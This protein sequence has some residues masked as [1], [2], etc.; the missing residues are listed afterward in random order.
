[1][2]IHCFQHVPFEGPA[3]IARWAS[4]RGHVLTA[5]RLWQAA[6]PEP[7]ADVDWLVIMGGPMNIHEHESYP[8]LVAEKAYIRR[9]IDAGKTV[10]G[11]CLGGQ[12]LADALG[13]AVTRGEQR[14]IGWYPIELTPQ[15]RASSL[16]GSVPNGCSVFHWHGD[17]F[18]IPRGAVRFAG[19]AGCR[20][21]AFLYGGRVLGLQFHLE[22]TP[23]SIAALL[24][25][26]ADE[27]VPATYVQTAEQML[28]RA[29]DRCRDL[30]AILFGILDRLSDSGSVV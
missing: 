7:L 27:V 5:T 26:C 10:I 29:Q 22:S 25:H 28:E 12:L 9:A 20:N 30:N 18:D 2:R 11:V 23:E 16:F 4:N 17:T 6:P 15:A 3:A 8:W 19:S 21:Q 13:A 14:E 1:M 24:E